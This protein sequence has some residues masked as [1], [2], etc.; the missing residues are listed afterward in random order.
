MYSSFFFLYAI[1][2]SVSMIDRRKGAAFPDALVILMAVIADRERP[3]HLHPKLLPDKLHGVQDGQPGIPF[4]AA[5]TAH[6]PNT[7]QRFGRHLMAGTP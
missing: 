2:L 3:C 5:G 4:A 6:F 7:V 1:V